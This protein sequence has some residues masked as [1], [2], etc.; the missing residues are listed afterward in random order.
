[1]EKM[2]EKD[3]D[4][5]VQRNYNID[6]LKILACLA[7]VCMHTIH[8]TISVVNLVICYTC[9]F[10]IP[11][12][13]S[14]SGF[15]LLHR[16]E[17]TYRYS[18]KKV[19]HIIRITFIWSFLVEFLVLI[20]KALLGKNLS[21]VSFIS[22]ITYKPYIQ[23]GNM[24]QFWYLGALAIVYMILPLLYGIIK[25]SWKKWLCVWIIFCIIC[26]AF[27]TASI[28]AGEPVQKDIIQTFRLWTWIQYFLAGGGIS[29]IISLLSERISIKLHGIIFAVWTIIAAAFQAYCGSFVI[30]DTH[31]EFYYDDVIVIIWVV[32][33]MSFILQIKLNDTVVKI[34]EFLSPLIMGVY[35][36]HPLINRVCLHFLTIDTVVGAILYSIFIMAVSFSGTYII[37]RL[38]F[39][40]HLIK[41]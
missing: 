19:L 31:P 28:Y 27:Q 24:W 37:Y 6:L 17:A 8:N 33:L 38:P 9:T 20:A 12:F 1:M 22:N 32:L 13:F 23:G 4:H 29:Y 15:I 21:V 34:V 30:H 7:V 18:L 41:I 2:I 10:A 16:K 39:G 3:K 26:L 14:S 40:K 5:V 35:I 11:V 25:G 36:I